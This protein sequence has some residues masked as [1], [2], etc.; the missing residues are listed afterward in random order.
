MTRPAYEALAHEARNFAVDPT[1]MVWVITV[2]ADMATSGSPAGAP[3][4][5]PVYSIAMDAETG[6]WTDYCVG[7]DWLKSSR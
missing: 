4:I 7:C 2:H 1:R 6:Q 3:K 5:F